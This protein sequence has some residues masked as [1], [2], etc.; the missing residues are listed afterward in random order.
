MITKRPKK[1]EKRWYLINAEN[2]VLGRL[3]TRIAEILRGKNKAE[4]S[5]D[6][7]CGDNVIVINAEKVRLTGNKLEKKIYTWHTGYP[8]GLKTRTVKEM[9]VKKPEFLIFNAVKG[10]LPKNKLRKRLLTHLRIYKGATHPHQAQN[11]IELTII[12]TRRV[13][14]VKQ[15]E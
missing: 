12:P 5:P 10:M 2:I 15:E 4:F 11:P 14:T 7:N 3:A 6:V 8:G 1:V 13:D 9:L